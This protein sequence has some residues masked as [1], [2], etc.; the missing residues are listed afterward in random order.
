MNFLVK[1]DPNEDMG[2]GVKNPKLMWKSLSEAPK[3]SSS[4][5]IVSLVMGKNEKE[6]EGRNRI[7]IKMG[8]GASSQRSGRNFLRVLR[9][10]AAFLFIIIVIRAE[11]ER[12]KT[13]AGWNFPYSGDTTIAAAAA[14]LMTEAL[15][16]GGK[17]TTN[18]HFLSVRRR[19]MSFF[20]LAESDSERAA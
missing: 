11:G 15:F 6:K 12:R 2:E 16:I 3:S 17:Q 1:S 8:G 18:A 13:L 20:T 19:Q 14:S 5:W 4:A 7:Q 10:P 9:P